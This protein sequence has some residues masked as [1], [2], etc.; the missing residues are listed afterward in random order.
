MWI[1]GEYWCQESIRDHWSDWTYHKTA[2][3][4]TDPLVRR[5]LGYG[6]LMLLV[7]GSWQERTQD[8]HCLLDLLADLKV[9]RF[10]LA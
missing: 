7:V 10:G 9:K 4:D 2:L 5:L 8:L 3:G 6:R 1:G